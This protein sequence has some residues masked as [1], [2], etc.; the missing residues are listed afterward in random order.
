MPQLWTIVPKPETTAGYTVNING[1]D[2]NLKVLPSTSNDQ[3]KVMRL[4]QRV[5]AIPAYERALTALTVHSDPI[6]QSVA[7]EA[8]R[9]GGLSE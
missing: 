1:P 7:F 5:A 9:K 8:L 6:V 4:A 2:G 3:A